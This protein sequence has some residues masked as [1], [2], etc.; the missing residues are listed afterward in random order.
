MYILNGIYHV[1]GW[2]NNLLILSDIISDNIDLSKE[3]D[4]SYIS[5]IDNNIKSDKDIVNKSVSSEIGR[6]RYLEDPTRQDILAA[7][8]ILGNYVSNR[9]ENH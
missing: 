8:G 5:S 3:N 9:H 7:A 1:T 6:V 4:K 2:H